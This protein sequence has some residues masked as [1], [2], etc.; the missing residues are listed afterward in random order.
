MILFDIEES[1]VHIELRQDHEVDLS[2]KLLLLAS[3]DEFMDLAGRIEAGAR[4]IGVASLVE[5]DHVPGL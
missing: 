2:H 3:I 5:L 1:V 4:S